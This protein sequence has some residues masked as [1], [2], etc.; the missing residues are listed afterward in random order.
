[1]YNENLTEL[2]IVDGERTQHRYDVDIDVTE[3][4]SAEKDEWGEPA[5]TTELWHVSSWH[6]SFN[7]EIYKLLKDILESGEP[8]RAIAHGEKRKFNTLSKACSD[9]CSDSIHLYN[10]DENELF[11]Y[12]PTH[13]SPL[14]QHCGEQPIVHMQYNGFCNDKTVENYQA[15]LRDQL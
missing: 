9:R 13:T 2:I 6:P 15:F 8:V 10:D 12:T 14:C 3:K 7:D 11:Y 4:V 5:Y 1:M